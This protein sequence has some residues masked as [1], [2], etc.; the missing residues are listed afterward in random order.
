MTTTCACHPPTPFGPYLLIF[1]KNFFYLFCPH[2]C[3]FFSHV[4]QICH[5]PLQWVLP[6]N[7]MLSFNQYTN[8]NKD[9]FF[10][11]LYLSSS[12]LSQGNWY[13]LC[14]F[15]VYG[16]ECTSSKTGWVSLH[17]GGAKITFKVAIHYAT[18]FILPFC[19]WF[20]RQFLHFTPLNI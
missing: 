17:F 6:I 11:F 19:H 15:H 4:F 9:Y 12:S 14:L 2:Q 5:L 8:W 10:T 18:M 3:S 13:I 1:L 16:L 7:S 20:F